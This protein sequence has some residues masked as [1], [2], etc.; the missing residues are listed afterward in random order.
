MRSHRLRRILKFLPF[1]V[2]FVVVFGFVVMGLWNWLMPA[3]FGLKPIGYWQAWGL[4]IL[5]RVLF[6][7]FRMG[8]RGDHWRHRMRERWEKMT[9]EEREK[10]RQGFY[11]R[12]GCVP[13]ADDKTSA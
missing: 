7:G 5:G 13:P 11:G 9:P 10:F 1:V 8:G 4:I 12:W 6:G 2:L 3:I